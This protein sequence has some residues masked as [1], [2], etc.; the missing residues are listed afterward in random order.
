MGTDVVARIELMSTDLITLS[1]DF[2]GFYRLE[3]PGLVGVA[4]ALTG[5][6]HD[7]E[8]LVQDTMVKAFVHWRRVSRLDR[9]GGWCHRVL[10]NGCRSWSRR[11]KSE[12]RFRSRARRDERSVAGP[13]ADIVAFWSLV[14]ELPSRPR[15]VMALHIAGERTMAEIA[16]I[17]GEPEGTVRSD[18][19]RARVLIIEGLRG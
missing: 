10:V 18:V 2:E 9:P 6:F 16:T 3:Y 11:R 7:A 4:A 5:D 15:M 17:L 19:A 13:S 1:W 8:D 14:R 12:Q